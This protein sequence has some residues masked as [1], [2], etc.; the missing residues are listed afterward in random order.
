LRRFPALAL[1]PEGGPVLLETDASHH[2]LRVSGIAPG[3]AVLLFDGEGLEARAL[4]RG[5]EGGRALL[6]AEPAHPTPAPPERWLLPSL[7]RHEAFDLI[8]RMATE[9]G[10]T[11]ILPVVASRSVARGDRADRWR[12]IA[13]S[14]AAQCGR[15]TLPIIDEP[16]PLLEALARVPEGYQRRVY[17]PL[18]ALLMPPVAPCALLLGPEGG[19][20]D[21]ELIQAC[22]AG[23]RAE[24]LEGYVLRADTAAVAVLA[25][26]VPA[27][28]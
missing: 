4:L 5:V 12:R 17:T 7:V 20:A 26:T 16:A 6:V 3:E 28:A 10:A 8:V 13:A 15:A 25:R 11:R 1:P 9:L 24:R 2:L 19:L 23:F 14:A 27:P 22:D 21:H 18:G